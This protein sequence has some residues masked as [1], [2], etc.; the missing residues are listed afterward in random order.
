MHGLPYPYLQE[1]GLLEDEAVETA[2]SCAVMA[3]QE[4]Q[5]LMINRL[6]AA[7]AGQ[8]ITQLVLNREITQMGAAFSLEPTVMHAK[9]ITK[10]NVE[11]CLPVG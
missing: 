6:V 5:S 10:A 2:V 4:A 8:L 3:Q 11:A 1:P 7:V 9:Q